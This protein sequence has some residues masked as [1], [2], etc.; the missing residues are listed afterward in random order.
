MGGPGLPLGESARLAGAHA[1]VEERLFAVLGASV[2]AVDDA[3]LK[4]ALARHAAMHAEHGAWWRA[5]LPVLAGVEPDALVAPPRNGPGPL[6][7][8]GS[9]TRP[10]LATVE[11]VYRRVLPAVLEA[12]EAHLAVASDVSDAPAIRTLRLVITEDEGARREGL[13]S[14][15]RLRAG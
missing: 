7:E 2:Q 14:L 13:V 8:L 3:G 12:Y 4:L 10:G 5:R 6:D 9:G 11:A 1:W 15:D